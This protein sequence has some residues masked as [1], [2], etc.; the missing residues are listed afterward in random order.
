MSTR[1]LGPRSLEGRVVKL[2]PLRRRH[3]AALFKATKGLEWGWFLRPLRTKGDVDERIRDGLRAERRGEAYAFAVKLKED[4]RIIGSTS[5]FGIS[6]RDKKVEVGSTWYTTDAQGTNVN[7]E[8]KLLLLSHAFEDWGAVRVQLTTDANNLHSQ[9][10]IVKLGAKYEGTLRSDKLRKDGSVRD[11]MVYS[12]LASEW[13]EVKM[14]LRA[15]I[16]GYRD[17]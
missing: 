17:S 10:A 8:C 2:E 15:R 12:I 6:P 9:H 4:D 5:Y 11:S 3:A 1:R 7:P 14:A 16:D 13:P